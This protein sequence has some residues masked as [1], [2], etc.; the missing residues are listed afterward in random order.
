LLLVVDPTAA[1]AAVASV[2]GSGHVAWK[3]G[4]VVQGMRGVARS[5]PERAYL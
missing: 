5:Q 3:L 2:I 4:K 1:D